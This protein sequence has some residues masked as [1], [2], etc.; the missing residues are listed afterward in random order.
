MILFVCQKILN[1][2]VTGYSLHPA[3]AELYACM[4]ILTLVQ[5]AEEGG[6]IEYLKRDTH[7]R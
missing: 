3:T 6:V 1:N 5:L 7:A 2:N 4:K